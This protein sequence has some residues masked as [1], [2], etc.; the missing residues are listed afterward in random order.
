MQQM[1]PERHYGCK[2]VPMEDKMIFY[3]K[4]IVLFQLFLLAVTLGNNALC[5][6][7]LE[8]D[9]ISIQELLEK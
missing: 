1:F 7:M 8:R 6:H 9:G 2:E 3:G 5:N 4:V